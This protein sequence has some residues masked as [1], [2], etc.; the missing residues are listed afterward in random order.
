[1]LWNMFVFEIKLRLR[2]VSTWIYFAIWFLMCFFSVSARDFGPVGNGKV[3]LNGPYAAQVIYTQLM[4]FGSIILAAIFGTSILRDFKENTLQLIFTRPIPKLAYLGGRWAGSMV[5]AAFVFSGMIFGMIAGSLAPWADHDRLAPIQLWWL[6]EPYLSLTLVQIFFLGSLYFMV[7]ALTRRIMV[8]YMQGVVLFALYLIGVI[9]VT[10]GQ[11]LD[12]FWPSVLDPLGL[13]MFGNVTKYW[14]VIERNTLLLSWHGEFLYNR[15]LWCG[16]GLLSL[17]IS[18]A[19]FPMSAEALGARAGRKAAKLAEADEQPS[20]KLAIPVVSRMFGSSTSWVQFWSL[21][22]VRFWNIVREI[23]FWAIVL[24]MVVLVVLNAR[25]V[26]RFRDTAVWPVTYLVVGVIG[27]SSSLFLLIVATLYTG[28]SIWRERDTKFEQ[29]HDA[30]P[31]AAWVNPLSQIAPVILVETILVTVVMLCGIL[32]Q[33]SLGYFHFQ[34][35]VYFKELYLIDL[36]NMLGL[37]FFAFFVHTMLPNK[38]FGHAVVIGTVLLVPVLEGIGVENRLLLFGEQTPYTYSDMN[39]Y[40]HFVP[41]LAT[42]QTYW[43]MFGVMLAS[44]AIAFAREG[45]DLAWKSRWKSASARLGGVAP[46]A[47]LAAVVFIA[48]GAWFYYNTHMVNHFRTAEENRK[49][50]AEYEK[51]YKKYEGLPQPK[52]NAVSLQVDLQPETRSFDATGEMH[53]VNKTKRVI[54]TIHIVNRTESIK[55]VDFDRPSKLELADTQHGYWI[56]RLAK[57]LEPGAEMTMHFQAGYTPH[58]FT[59]GNERAELAYNGM[60]FDR[61]YFPGIGYSAGGE[62]SDPRRRKEQ[63]LGPQK[64]LPLPGDPGSDETNLFTQDADR[65]TFRAVVSTAPDQIAVAPGY[66]QKEWT[67]NGRRYFEY[68]MGDQKIENFYSFISGR[69]NVKR[70]EYKGV[71][72]EIYYH[73]GH[74]YNL[75][76]MLQASR[77]GLDYFGA[78]F[79]PYQ[80]QQFRI[81]EY[82]RYRG[83]A[84]SFPNTVPYSEGL[85]FIQRVEKPED[86][87]EIFYITAHELAH[88]WWGHQLVGSNSQ[89]SN[90]MSESLAQYSALMLMEKEYGKEMI[91]KFLKHELDG[92]LRGRAAERRKE[93]TLSR[94]QN[95]AYVWYQ[96]GSLVMYALRDYMGEEALNGAL[97]QFLME[98]RYVESA[99]PNADQFVAALQA[100]APPQYRQLVADSFH[101]IILFDNRAVSATYRETPDKKYKVTVTVESHKMKA[102]GQGKE[103][104]I[105]VDD[106]IDIGVMNGDGKNMKPLFLE[107]RHLDGKQ[108]K[109][110]I[111]VDSLPSRAGIDPLN[112]LIDRKPDDNTMAVTK[113]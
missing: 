106:W 91:G 80:F 3:L 57:P 42:I 53:M 113:E 92:Y 88:Q 112:K 15:L 40:G 70:E 110:E 32:T 64:E 35:D 11:S 31:V 63:G 102:D 49:L 68:S 83:F 65:I 38:F 105:P 60:F 8:V 50:Q 55:K 48:S 17:V 69:F 56:Y 2:Q 41:A 4:A 90:M 25:E 73:P 39:G 5:I 10:R 36:M 6:I 1:M 34:P 81:L 67:A 95:D 43:L 111:T 66:L 76:R 51:L 16:V 45:T 23:P 103:T 52:I 20:G 13:L 82:P 84:Q 12:T 77:K 75:E 87:D 61:D 97:H 74:E 101:S 9:F 62:I 30:L 86:I 21:T 71:K 44:A 98:H 46:V 93:E 28:E 100:A 24:V 19:A 85:G 27:G 89:G 94:V 78:N 99:Y 37:V 58:G 33:A 54:E 29:I 26:G 22:R 59:D 7:A 109:F 96:K 72:L 14:T 107:K 104:D 79:S 108:A 47:G 18:F